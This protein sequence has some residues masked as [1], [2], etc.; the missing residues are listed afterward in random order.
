MVCWAWIL[1]ICMSS[2]DYN[3]TPA[4]RT[5]EVMKRCLAAKDGMLYMNM[6]FDTPLPFWYVHLISLLVNVQ[7]LVMALK[8]GIIFAQAF[9]LKDYFAMAQSFV[10]LTVLVGLYQGILKLTCVLAE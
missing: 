2:L 3:R 7:N 9:A 10:S 1:R 5:S 4:P 8:S 6:H